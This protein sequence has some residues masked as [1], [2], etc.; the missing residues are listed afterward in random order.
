MVFNL[1]KVCDISLDNALNI[2]LRLL[3][4]NVKGNECLALKRG[5]L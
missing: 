2:N 4:K 3:V 5:K 1:L